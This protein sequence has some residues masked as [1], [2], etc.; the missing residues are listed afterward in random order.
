[1]KQIAN[2]QTLL[3][4]LEGKGKSK[5]TLDGVKRHILQIAKRANLDNTEEVELAIA[6]YKLIDPI[7]KQ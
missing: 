5:N 2:I 7:T 1:L 4:H 6:R 3:L